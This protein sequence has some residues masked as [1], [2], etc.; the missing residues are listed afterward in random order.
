MPLNQ[1]NG[2][3]AEQQSQRRFIKGGDAHDD[4]RRID[5]I[6]RLGAV[7]GALELS[8]RA[9]RGIVIGAPAAESPSTCQQRRYG[10]RPFASSPM[11][12]SASDTTCQHLRTLPCGWRRRTRVGVLA[13][14]AR[15][16]AALKPA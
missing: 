13:L 15:R 5:G 11:S 8:H 1:A 6:A 2:I 14:G 12:S 7:V 16:V 3:T 9:D 4:G 10:N